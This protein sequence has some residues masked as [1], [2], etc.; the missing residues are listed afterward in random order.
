MATNKEIEALPVN[1]SIKRQLK[2][3]Q[4]SPVM[5]NLLNLIPSKCTWIVPRQDMENYVL[6]TAEE[7]LGRGEV[8]LVTIDAAPRANR[9]PRT[10]VWIDKNSRH[11]VDR[12]ISDNDAVF[13]PTVERYSQDLRNFADQFAPTEMDD[14]T[15]IN[16]KKRIKL[17]AA[18]GR[19][20][21][22][23]IG[24]YIDLSRILSRLFD[25]ENRGFQETFGKDVP[26]RPCSIHCDLI[27]EKRGDS[28]FVMAVQVVKYFEGNQ[29]GHARPRPVKNY[30]DNGRRDNND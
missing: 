21:S 13:V 17:T 1:D 27:Y 16:R 15:P 23:I 30:Y 24:I 25:V 10:V 4:Q 22:G 19:E 14:G 26:V 29:T 7:F 8:K 12:S 9:A 6:K 5:F 11:L 20:N 3:L 18:E 28:K 2:T